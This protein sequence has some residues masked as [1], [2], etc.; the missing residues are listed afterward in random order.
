MN[1]RPLD[2]VLSGADGALHGKTV[3]AFGGSSVD[4]QVHG[5][6]NPETR[7]LSLEDAVDAPDAGRYSATL[8]EDGTHMVGSFQFRDRGD[9]VAFTATRSR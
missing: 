3:V 2:I 8:T 6:Y 1:G 9:K 5:S 7:A 4:T